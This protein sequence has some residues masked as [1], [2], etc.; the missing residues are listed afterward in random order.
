MGAMGGT[1]M[2]AYVIVNEKSGSV[3]WDSTEEAVEDLTAQFERAGA[4]AEIHLTDGDEAARRLQ[5]GLASDADAIF[6][7]GGDGTLTRSA[8]DFL[9]QEKPMG[10]L[11]LGT[12]N[13]VARDLR[14]P[15][16]PNEAIAQLVA[17]SVMEIDVA[18]V[19]EAIY[20]THAN[21]GHLTDLAKRREELRD[22]SWQE[23]VVA[24]GRTFY[25]NLGSEPP[26]AFRLRAGGK[27]QEVVTPTLAVVVGEY[28]VFDPFP[29]RERLDS[30]ELTVYVSEHATGLEA[31]KDALRVVVA[32]RD[33]AQNVYRIR[34]DAVTVDGPQKKLRVVLDGEIQEMEFPL[35]FEVVPK[36]L[37]VLV[38]KEPVAG[39][40]RE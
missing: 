30:G 21:I 28:G 12:F 27:W 32:Q 33:T 3:R 17:G 36:Q 9:G 23:K 1:R 15:L 35:R 34:S 31:I 14:I 25:E 38:P 20:L 40:A 13:L 6:L 22:K 11:P 2:K 26:F 10:V 16:E 4:E 18:R 5:E 29:R 7:G 37:K 19:N 24:I 39:E 8:P